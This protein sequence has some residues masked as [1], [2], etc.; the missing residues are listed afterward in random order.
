MKGQTVYI[1]VRWVR[2]EGVTLVSAWLDDRRADAVA[3]E[4]N[5]AVLPC[6]NEVEFRVIE[7]EAK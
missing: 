4:L 6:E 1:V 2:F 5:A 7:I 3:D